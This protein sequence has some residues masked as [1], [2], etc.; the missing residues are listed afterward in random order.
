[1]SLRPVCRALVLAATLLAC[2]PVAA[3]P[4]PSAS[5]LPPGVV[6]PAAWTLVRTVPLTGLPGGD[7]VAAL[8]RSTAARGE[9]GMGDPLHLVDLLVWQGGR[10]AWRF[11]DAT[12]RDA[13]G[14][15]PIFQIDDWLEARDLTGDSEPEIIFHAGFNGVS[16]FVRVTHVAHQSRCENSWSDIARPEFRESALAELRWLDVAG[17]ATA[18]VARPLYPASPSA[19][20]GFC[21]LCPHFY[22]F[23]A[24][25]WDARRDSFVVSAVALSP[26]LINPEDDALAQGAPLLRS[27]LPAPAPT[28]RADRGR[29]QVAAEHRTAETR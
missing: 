10:V 19:D 6:D 27:S 13:S 2:D 18:F 5:G 1:M 25:A 26:E 7:A 12:T 20:L 24:F 17:Q 28:T 14:T 3:Q 11:S 4:T 21:H 29:E 23:L 9:S 15:E 8:L 16:D 22:E